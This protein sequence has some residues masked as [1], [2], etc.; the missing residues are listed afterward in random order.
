[1]SQLVQKPQVSSKR[2]LN[3]SI[4][5]PA[6][7]L[8]LKKLVLSIVTLA[9]TIAQKKLYPP[10]V[11]VCYRIAEAVLEHEG[12]VVCSL[13]SRQFGKCLAEGT[14][15]MMADTTVRSVEKIKMGDRVMGDDG[16][17]RTVTSLASGSE[18]MYEIRPRTKYGDSYTV[19]ESHILSLL[20]TKRDAPSRVEDICVK[21]VLKD[22]RIKTSHL[23]GYRGTFDFPEKEVPIDPYWLGLWLGDGNS[24]SPAIYNKDPEVLLRIYKYA[25]KLG[26]DV[27]V[28]EEPTCYGYNIVGT[29]LNLRLKA[30]RLKT[31]KHIPRAYFT[32][33][34]KVRLELLAG[35]IDSDGSLN[36]HTQTTYEICQT[37]KRLADDIVFLARSLGFRA[38]HYPRKTKCQTGVEG[39]AYRCYIYGDISTIPVVVRRKKAKKQAVRE[40]PLS[41]GIKIVPKGVGKYYGF[42]LSG[43]NRRF[44]LGDFTVTHNTEALGAI[45]AALCVMLPYLAKK[46]PDSWHLN[47][48]DD[49]GVYRGFRFG[50]KVG[51]YAPRR[52]Q[53]QIM[54]DRIKTIFATDSAKQVLKEIKL[55]QE[56]SNGNSVK[57][58]N[59]SRI[60]CESASEQS[61][62]EGATHDLLVAE[63]AQDISDLKIRKSLRPMI[64]ST[65]GC[66]VM[67]GTA[68]GKK[69][70]FYS[71]LKIAQRSQLVTGKQ[72]SFVYPYSIC[73][74]YN[75]LY[76]DYIAK[77]K[78]RLGED[79]DEFLTSY[80][81]LLPDSRI[82]TL[83][84]SSKKLRE[85]TTTD[86]VLGHTGNFRPVTYGAKKKWRQ[87]IYKIDL[88][89]HSDSVELTHDHES[90]TGRG[91]VRADALRK[92]DILLYPCFELSEKVSIVE[93]QS[94]KTKGGFCLPSTLLLSADLGELLGWY[95]AEG[96]SNQQNKSNV[97]FFLNKK[98]KQEAQRI[99]QL[100]RSFFGVEARLRYLPTSLSVTVNCAHLNRWLTLQFGHLAKNK[101]LPSWFLNAPKDFLRAFIRAYFEGDGCYSR[102]G[103]K[104]WVASAGSA[105]RALLEQIG[106]ILSGFK[107]ASSFHEGVNARSVINGRQIKESRLYCLY[108][109]GLASQDIFD[110][111]NTKRASSYLSKGYLFRRIKR[112]S[113]RPYI[114][115]VCD[116]T[117]DK[118]QSFSTT[119]F[120][121]HNCIW[122]FERG[123]FVTQEQLF[124]VSTACKAGAFSY[125]YPDGH[126]NALGGYSLVAGI[127]W[128]KS[129]DSTV[130]CLAAVNWNHPQ[131]RGTY[132]RHGVQIEYQ[133][134]KKHIVGF[135]ELMGDNYEAQFWSI[136]EYLSKF[137]QL[138]KIVNDANS[139][140][141]PMNDRLDA[142]YK[143]RG[144]LVEG[145]TFQ[146]KSKS[147]LYKSYYS[148]LCGH[149]VT[150]P[151][152]EASRQTKEYRKFVGQMLDLTKTYRNGNMVVCHPPEKDCHDDF[153]DAS[154]LALWGCNTSGYAN[155]IDMHDNIFY[156]R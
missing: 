54:F 102:S 94:R 83:D 39:E 55:T 143:P 148:D 1:M 33:S 25:I 44:M 129:H 68:T 107:I 147:D 76:R 73:Q 116:I 145:F 32:N 36:K 132:N 53:A 156:R 153:P 40:N 48:T 139:C 5:D 124:N 18:K 64:A 26:G 29:D 59:N 150:F 62:I 57:L 115:E 60:L 46:Y 128:G 24:R 20:A 31:N 81:C 15:V 89:G 47:I 82:T 79:S 95:I 17:P 105:S 126:R 52:A 106:V 92:D 22:S 38:Y 134:F 43:K 56:V 74:N 104:R 45:I 118:D 12:E 14:Q 37:S 117:V 93:V 114:G 67:I 122:I 10:Q 149:R 58:S 109:Y 91:W 9:Q 4:N 11:K 108:V 78:I 51:I 125:L 146:A 120:V 154:A 27:S 142:F 127:D 3:A 13:I 85:I 88:L 69:C 49:N 151:C 90:L 2:V 77:E 70:E 23:L 28:Y 86:F 87:P 6:K 61:K 30:L 100:L 121:V 71:A 8:D 103:K 99:R 63:E 111:H 65:K 75:S 21:D 112:I 97:S 137:P 96:C 123:M 155:S 138:A 98:E 131:E 80:G 66:F 133:T 41:Y 34:R 7:Q 72:N 110:K 113:R 50:F 84:G 135:M 119:A 141:T 140:G 101:K 152:G 144:V 130:V 16:T 19:N 42:T 136:V 35:L